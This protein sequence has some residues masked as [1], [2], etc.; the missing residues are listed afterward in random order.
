MR[1]FV[2]TCFTTALLFSTACSEEKT[3]LNNEQTCI[4]AAR[5]AE[6]PLGL[7]NMTA[8]CYKLFKGQYPNKPY[9]RCLIMEWNQRIKDQNGTQAKR[10]VLEI[11]KKFS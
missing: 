1:M 5:S 2:M 4:S 10:E 3:I 8:A 7:K 11:C 9:A 6:H